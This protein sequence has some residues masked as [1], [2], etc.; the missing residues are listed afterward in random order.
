VKITPAGKLAGLTGNSTHFRLAAEAHRIRLAFQYDPHFAVSVSQVDPLPHQMDAVYSHLLT[1]PQIRFL[2]ADDPG[3]GKTIMAGLT[4]KELKYRGLVERALIVTP[5]NLTDQWRRELKDKF[6]EVFTVINRGTVGSA[7]GRNVWEDSP[8]CI[9][10]IDF[11]ARQDDI[12]NQLRDV[13]WDIVIVDE[14]HKMAAYRYGMKV[15]KT[16]RYE[17]GEFVQDRTDHLLFLTATPHKGDPDNFALLL[18]LLDKDLYVTGNILAEASARGENRIM[19]RRLKEDM[20]KFD[21]S[22]CFP[23]RKVQTLPYK[24][25]TDELTLYEAV[26]DYV[27]HNFQRAMQAENRN[28]G[29]ALTVLQRRL[30]SSMAA[31]RLSLERRL[32]RLKD[33]QRLG[34]IKQ[35][36]GEIPE[37]M[38]DLT[39]ADRW[40]FEDEL[41]ERLTMAGTM[42]ELEAE[43][44]DLEGLVKLAKHNEKHVPETK[45]E[46]LREVVSRHLAGRE[47]RLLVFTEHKDTLDFLVRKLTDL[48]FHCCTIHGGMPLEKRI[49]AEREF[50][51]RKPSIMVAT[52]AAGEGIN[53]QFCSLMA[54]YDIPW[55]P[56]RLEQR[57]GRI[58]RYGQ[59]HEVM[60][61]N[62]VAK[63]TREGE[64]MD[65]LLRKLEDMRKA[66][67][68]DRVYDVIGAIM[69]A[70]KFDALMKD[71]LAKRRTMHEILA[72]IDLQTDE[73]QVA[74]IR[75]DMDDKAL[76]S[77]YIDLSKLNA[78]RQK[79]K[80]DRLMPEY[81]EKF[82]VEA[83]RSFGGTIGPV[84]SPLPSPR[85]GE[86]LGVRDGLWTISRVPPDLR[87]L[88]ETMERRY[89]KIGQTYPQITFDKEQAV[90]YSEVEFVGP[91]HPLFEGVVERVLRHYGGS[92]RQGAVFFNAE[93]TEPTVLWLL[94]CGVEDGRGQTVGERLVAVHCTEGRYRKSQPYALLDLKSPDSLAEVPAPTRQVATGEDAVISW[95]LEGVTPDY[96]AEIDERRSRELGIKEKYIRK[97]LQYLIGESVKKIGKYDQQLRQMR[98]ETDPKRLNLMGNRAKEEARKAELSQ[99]LKD[100]LAEIEQE[101]HLSEKPPE[102]LGVAVIL[103]LPEEVVQSV[104]GMESDPEVEAIAI[105]EAKK[106]EISQGRKPVSVE[107]ENCGW[108]LTS[109]L[110]GQVDRYIEVKGRGAVGGVALTPNE[111]IKAQRFGKDYWLYVVVNCKSQPELHLIQDPASKLRPTEEVSVVRYLIEPEDW[112]NAAVAGGP[113]AQM[114]GLK[115]REMP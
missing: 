100:R 49:E 43:I 22:P 27:Q 83:Y 85:G 71:W 104:E 28:V 26:T 36:F 77:R 15:N 79:S 67:G 12:L 88:S 105:A 92:L 40:K 1:Q 73:Q 75:A 112:R 54:N 9:T 109:L 11:V 114:S 24:L 5:A 90:G 96:F 37:D 102:I 52:E 59:Q 95:S 2:I 63:N 61:F 41:V 35:E 94:R 20:K 91:G 87:K 30:A 42:A 32:K 69:S 66:L 101:R 8:Q 106:Y 23:P 60:I 115:Q 39:E 3:A 70:P 31:I 82:F 93:A 25:T 81:I 53:L 110:G 34:K 17:F 33:L 80:E 4:L 51:E 68:S 45:F 19:I 6:G 50:F 7:Y 72:E 44:G 55:N 76:G 21:G 107:E 89:G 16:Q 13:R 113:T 78:D 99:R 46:E 29:L 14:A 65:R 64:V 62:L 74:R 47:E 103:P 57:M 97:S 98:D 108:D 58:H 48:G 56:N 84:K 18:Q 111:W 38:D 10:S 86:G